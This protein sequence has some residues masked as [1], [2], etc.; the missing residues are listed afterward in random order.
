MKVRITEVLQVR[1]KVEYENDRQMTDAAKQGKRGFPGYGE[2]LL[3]RA[4]LE[5][6][7]SSEVDIPPELEHLFK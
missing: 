5:K 4:A 7:L 1:A 2:L 3:V 6:I